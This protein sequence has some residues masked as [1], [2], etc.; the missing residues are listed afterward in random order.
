MPVAFGAFCKCLQSLVEAE[1]AGLLARR[2]FLERGEKLTHVLLR[3]HEHEGVVHAPPSVVDAFVVGALERIGAQVEELRKTQGHERVLPDIQ[4]VRAL[5]REDDLPLVVA[6]ADQRA[7][8]V[9]VEELLAR[10]RRLAGE[11]IGDVV[12]VEWTLKVLSPTFMPFNSC[13]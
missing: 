6:Q 8:V 9:E 11:R 7:V 3:R 13:P 1:A 4:A 2:E 5:F 12:A 10:A